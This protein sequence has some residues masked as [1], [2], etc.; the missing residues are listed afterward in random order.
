MIFF[1][2]N[3]WNKPGLLHPEQLV[4]TLLQQNRLD[5]GL[6]LL[7]GEFGMNLTV[8]RDTVDPRG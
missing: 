2:L 4:Q 3:L 7:R 5:P 1:Q 8:G 6:Q